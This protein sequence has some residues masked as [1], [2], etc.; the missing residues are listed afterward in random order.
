MHIL[1][2]SPEFQR[3][4]TPTAF[5]DE[6]IHWR[7]IIQLNLIRSI[8]TIL[9]ALADVRN[10]Q[11]LSL[12]PRSRART[13][14]SG[15]DE[16]STLAPTVNSGYAGGSGANGRHG[17]KN[18][19]EQRERERDRD[20]DVERERMH[21]LGQYPAYGHGR[22][23]Y[24]EHGYGPGPGAGPAYGH[25]HGHHH[26][27]SSPTWGS[28]PAM[29]YANANA[30]GSGSGSGSGSSY[31][32][33]QT[34]TFN[35][36]YSNATTTIPNTSYNPYAH[37][38][39]IPLPSHP[40]EE[41][42][43]DLDALAARLLPLQH[44]ESLLKAK[45]VPPNEEE[46]VD[47]GATY[48]ASAG[49]NG[50]NGN[51]GGMAKEIYVRPGR[52]RASFIRTV[53]ATR[54]GRPRTSSEGEEGE[55]EDEAQ[56]VLYECREDMMALWRSQRVREVLA[57]KRVRL[58]DESGFFLNDLERVTEEGYL[59]TDGTSFINPWWLEKVLIHDGLRMGV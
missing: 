33:N 14:D 17:R 18:S 57:L 32:A 23:E 40:G 10:T 54:Q 13:I 58:E 6:R 50:M 45:L 35:S 44:I 38:H 22:Q 48:D 59:P 31:N 27:S 11:F 1:T 42:N 46:A 30:S 12:S 37:S 53:G 29:S 36:S 24:Y 3:L 8:H 21:Q 39:S 47:L 55:D 20:R 41:D 28:P 9:A 52:W 49:M 26:G 15:W 4:Y 16:T 5:R 19:R 51:G 25:G 7:S 34:G 43:E 2:R 56:R